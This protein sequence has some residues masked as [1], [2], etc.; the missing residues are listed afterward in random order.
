VDPLALLSVDD[1]IPSLWRWVHASICIGKELDRGGAR[2][3][4]ILVAASDLHGAHTWKFR[5]GSWAT[6]H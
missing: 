6:R 3:S 1:W 5:F 2:V 4:G